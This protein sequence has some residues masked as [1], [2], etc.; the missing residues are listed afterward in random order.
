MHITYTNNCGEEKIMKRR[1][2]L[3][4]ILVFVFMSFPVVWANEDSV[5]ESNSQIS[6]QNVASLAPLLKSSSSGSKSSSSSSSSKTKVKDGDDDDTT[7]T[8]ETDDSNG[9]F[10]WWIIAIIVIVIL[11]I[12]GFIVWY[13]F[14]R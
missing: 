13:L 4:S 3:I 9:G 5:G 8:N 6:S 7:A 1:I 12:I 14:L 2:I 11:G 10:P